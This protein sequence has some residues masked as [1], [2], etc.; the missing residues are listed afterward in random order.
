MAAVQ[1]SSDEKRPIIVVKRRRPGGAGHHGGAWKVA[2]ADFVTAMMAFFMVMWL[3]A[4]VSNQ[5]RAAIYEY[6]RNPS[7]DPGKS[8]KPAPGQMG[9]GGASTSPINMQGGLDAPKTVQ[10]KTSE[11]TAPIALPIATPTAGESEREQKERKQLDALMQDL[12]E[13]INKSQALEPFKDQLLLDIM[14]EGLRIQIVDAKNRPMFDLGSARLKD[15]TVAILRE[16]APYLSSVENRMM[17]VG[18]T[19]VTAYSGAAGYTNWELS[20]D[21]ANSARRALAQG[22]VPEEKIARVVGM[23]SVALFDKNDPKNPINRRISIIVMTKQADDRNSK[24]DLPASRVSEPTA[25][26]VP[27]EMPRAAS[28]PAAPV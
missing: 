11:S 14:P 26:S 7:M 28:A 10:A 4:S 20:A 18:H 23:G 27:V 13:A 24:M 19:D 5:Q 22:G 25:A 9:P 3:V 6:F 8:T 16:L 15:Y 12:K 1:S 21:R 17:L 2:Y